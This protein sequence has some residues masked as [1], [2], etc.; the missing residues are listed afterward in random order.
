M[1]KLYEGED[2]ELTSLQ[3]ILNFIYEFDYTLTESGK[4]IAQKE[5]NELKY[6]L[7]EAIAEILE[8][9]G[10]EHITRTSEGYILELQHQEFG[11]IPVELNIKVKNL[12]FDIV[13]AEEDWKITVEEKK[14]K[15][16]KK[17]RD[18]AAKE[19]RKAKR[20]PKNPETI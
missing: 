5:R 13:A 7:T 3:R 20:K 1:A 18:A 19:A 10:I 4:S 11:V 6:N 16:E 9:E 15:E 17:V 12:D 14:A 2:Y 8:V